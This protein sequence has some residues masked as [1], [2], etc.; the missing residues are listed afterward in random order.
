MGN[1]VFMML[2][3]SIASFFA[4]LD[5]IVDCFAFRL[6]LMYP[7]VPAV[8]VQTFEGEALLLLL[9]I[10]QEVSLVS[11]ISKLCLFHITGNRFLI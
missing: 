10:L 4:L 2:L 9:L 6:A 8:G 3:P 7:L 5:L 11:V 1:P